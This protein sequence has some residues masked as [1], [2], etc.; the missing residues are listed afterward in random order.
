MGPVAAG[1]FIPTVAHRGEMIGW[2]GY[3]PLS[4]EQLWGSQPFPSVCSPS[5]CC[6]RSTCI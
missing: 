3:T 5:G 6:W 2:I 1:N 4:P